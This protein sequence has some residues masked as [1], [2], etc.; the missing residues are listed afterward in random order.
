MSVQIDDVI[1]HPMDPLRPEALHWR[2]PPG[3]GYGNMIELVRALR[4]KGVRPMS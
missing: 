1:E 2:L 3:R 4:D